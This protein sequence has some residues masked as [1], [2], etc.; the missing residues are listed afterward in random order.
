MYP[1]SLTQIEEPSVL[2]PLTLIMDLYAMAVIADNKEVIEGLKKV[3][4]GGR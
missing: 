3:L 4:K 2:I 1:V